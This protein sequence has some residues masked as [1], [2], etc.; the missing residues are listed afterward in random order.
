MIT[1]NVHKFEEIQVRF[2]DLGINLEHIQ[3][4]YPEAQA[5]TIRDIAIQSAATIL[6]YIQPPFLIED[7]GIAIEQL[8]GFPGPYSSFVFKT[9]GWKGI[10]K[11][12]RDEKNRKARFISVI[13]FIDSFR[14]MHVFEGIQEGHIAE[15][16]RG[17][18]GFGFDPIFIPE[19]S[20]LTFA[21]MDIQTKNEYSHRGKSSGQLYHFLAE[22]Q[23]KG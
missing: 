11:L 14:Q 19:G 3:F 13:V 21:E 15:E 16:G 4:P 2:S 17:N 1:S 10:L 18:K 5:E 20:K 12:M 23:M 6:T 8:K 22:K 7:S 9:V